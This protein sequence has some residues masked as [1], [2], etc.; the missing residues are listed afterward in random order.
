MSPINIAER[1]RTFG[2]KPSSPRIAVYH[3]LD[4]MRNHPT[5]DTIYQA[6]ALDYPT[7]SRT[8]VYNTVRLFLEHGAIQP[9]LIED[10]EMRYDADISRHGH[11]KC[12]QCG[13][14]SD[15]FF[16]SE[17]QLPEP[18]AGFEAREI[19]LYY[20]GCCAR[21]RTGVTPAV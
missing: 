9:V 8:T 19:H 10:G 13:A 6:L 15:L 20:R 4:T 3:Y 2:I 18:P 12:T 16:D 14:V 11:C 1:L 5:A 17:W 21:C 7:L